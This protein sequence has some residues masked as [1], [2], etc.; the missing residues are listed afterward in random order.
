MMLSKNYRLL[1][2]ASVIVDAKQKGCHPP[3]ESTSYDDN[4]AFQLSLS[5]SLSLSWY[6]LI[7]VLATCSAISMDEKVHNTVVLT[8]AHPVGLA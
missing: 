6:L 1:V 3:V 8:A 7:I 4:N 5:L 2:A